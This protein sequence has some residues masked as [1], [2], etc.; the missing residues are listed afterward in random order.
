MDLLA[1]QPVENFSSEVGAK[2][3]LQEIDNFM[4]N[5]QGG[6]N[7]KKMNQL[8][9]LCKKL[10]KPSIDA[11]VKEALERIENV[12]SMLEKRETR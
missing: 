3:C 5:G 7:M 4:Q 10:Q 12:K 8:N 1:S 6:I 11:M 9:T 2:K